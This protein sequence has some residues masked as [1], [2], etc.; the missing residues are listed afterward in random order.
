MLVELAEEA[1]EVVVVVVEVEVQQ[2]QGTRSK[3]YQR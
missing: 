2:Q 3:R 1:A